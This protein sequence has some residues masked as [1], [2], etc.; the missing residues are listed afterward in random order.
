M[1]NVYQNENQM[2]PMPALPPS[3]W[4]NQLRQMK[5]EMA[6]NDKYRLQVK[7]SLGGR[8]NRSAITQKAVERRH[9]LF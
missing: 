8:F 9:R 4:E 2:R 7:T 1:A 5:E 3:Y 6:A